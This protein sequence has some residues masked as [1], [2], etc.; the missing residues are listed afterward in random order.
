V[1]DAG[2]KTKLIQLAGRLFPN[3]LVVL[4]HWSALLRKIRLVEHLLVD[5]EFFRILVVAVI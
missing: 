5:I 4:E 2:Q 3:G 1:P